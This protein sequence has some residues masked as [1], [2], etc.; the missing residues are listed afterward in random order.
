MGR[1]DHSDMTSPDH[2]HAARRLR[3]LLA[4]LAHSVLTCAAF[5]PF[6]LWPLAYL[7]IVPL[8]WAAIHTERPFWTAMLVW[9]GILPLWAFQS[10]WVTEVSVAGFF[11]MVLILAGFGA[12]FVWVLARVRSGYPRLP[13]VVVAPV[14]WTGI[15]YLRGDVAFHGFGWLL[16]GHPLIEMPVLARPAA[17][18]GAYFVSFL[19]AGWAALIAQHF[20]CGSQRRVSLIAAGVLVA[21]QVATSFSVGVGSSETI[22]IGVVQTNVPQDNKIGWTIEQRLLDW[23]SILE[24]TRGFASQDVDLVLWPETMF[25]GSFLDFEAVALERDAELVFGVE[26]ADG[27]VERVASTYFVDSLLDLQ[28]ELGLPLIVGA[29]GVDNLKIE[30]DAAGQV[31]SSS[32]ARFNSAFVI[33]DGRVDPRRYDKLHLTPFGEVMP[34]IS[35]WPWLEDQFLSIGAGGMSFDLSAGREPVVLE[36]PVDGWGEGVIRIGTP[37]CFEVAKPGV[38]RRLVYGG[39]G[40][41]GGGRRADILLSLTN[42]GWFT[43]WDAGRRQHLQIDQWRALELGT[44]VVRAANTGI[45]AGIDHRG[46]VL[47]TDE[48]LV[49]LPSRVEGVL[50]VE[51]AVGSSSTLYGRLGDVFAIGMLVLGAML[52]GATFVSRRVSNKGSEPA[53]AGK[54][55]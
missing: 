10:A 41:D 48:G 42:D 21:V 6:G 17:A 55:S 24:M 36:V 7:A 31:R 5:A 51:T 19:V 25:P 2:T 26:R 20:W 53:S 52:G 49:K 15:E 33:S 8:I 12:G 40:G 45:S 39:V 54:E 14:L 43:W 29:T 18:L 13:I 9:V 30:V 46:R 37:I 27:T 50:V 44:P 23:A 11:P 34:Y 35:A 1:Y 22:R 38:C 28:Q 3:P 16:L 4:G 47:R 32:D